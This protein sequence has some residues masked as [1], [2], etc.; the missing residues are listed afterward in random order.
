MLVRNFLEVISTYLTTSYIQVTMPYSKYE[1][2]KERK[3][4][5]CIWLH[6]RAVGF[7]I[8]RHWFSCLLGLL[9]DD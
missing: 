4:G 8:K 3:L 1:S 5:I 7:A 6:C 9:L 2:M